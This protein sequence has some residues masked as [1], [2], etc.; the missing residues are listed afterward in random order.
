MV[1]A[2]GLGDCA[3]GEVANQR[4]IYLLGMVLHTPDWILR[5]GQTKGSDV[6][7]RM[8]D[9][10]RC[11]NA[12]L[13]REAAAHTSL[14]GMSTTMT[15]AVT[16]GDDLIVTHVGD[17]RAYLQ[18]RGNLQRLTRDHSLA[19]RLMREGVKAPND[20]LS[21][22]LRGILMQALGAK[23]TECK[24]EVNHF[25][26]ADGD[27]LMLCTDGLTDQV[28]EQVIEDVRNRICR[29]KS[30]ARRWWISH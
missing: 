11:V 17:S 2:D 14:N 4:A 20:R 27:C 26:L 3:A 5:R 25:D 28:D 21:R 7:E 19:E 15:V 16:L 23:D 18:R 30:P 29:P 9:R 13:L 8:K 6:M 24:P 1:V 10:F 22:E 12:A